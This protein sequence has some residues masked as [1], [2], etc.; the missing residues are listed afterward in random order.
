[1]L[2]RVWLL[3]SN[4]QNY[5]PANRHLVDLRAS[6]RSQVFATFWPSFRAQR[7]DFHFPFL[8]LAWVPLFH[9][10]DVSSM[11]LKVVPHAQSRNFFCPLHTASTLFKNHGLTDF[12]EGITAN[13]REGKHFDFIRQNILVVTIKQ[14]ACPRKWMPWKCLSR[15]FFYHHRDRVSRRN[16]LWYLLLNYFRQKS[17]VHLGFFLHNWIF[18]RGVLLSSRHQF[19]V[20]MVNCS[21]VMP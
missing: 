7:L 17:K 8:F 10:H 1:M 6:L 5:L 12:F 2:F 18:W 13:T 4:L 9:E 15:N 3:S 11:L 20:E 14:R 16:W 21:W 19:V